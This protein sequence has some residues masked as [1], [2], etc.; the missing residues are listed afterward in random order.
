MSTTS[1]SK[2][3]TAKT[4]KVHYAIV[5]RNSDYSGFTEHASAENAD[6]RILA[7]KREG[8]TVIS[9]TQIPVWE[10]MTEAE[11]IEMDLTEYHYL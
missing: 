1:K 8:W 10:F 9:V 4:R 6:K 7:A 3:V 5:L 2:K 11:A